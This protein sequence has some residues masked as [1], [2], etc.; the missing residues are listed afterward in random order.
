[1]KF[2]ISIDPPAKPAVPADVVSFLDPISI[3]A[4]FGLT[5]SEALQFFRQKGLKTSFDYK[6][7]IKEEHEA[8]FT[9]A[10]MLDMDMLGAVKDRID[11]AIASGTSMGEFRKELEPYLVKRGWWGQQSITDPLTGKKSIEKLGSAYRLNNI[12]RTNMQSAYSVGQWEQIQ[13]QAENAP[14]LMYD[15]VDDHRTRPE[16]VQWDGKT[17]PVNAPF[18]K[19]HY[20]PNDYGCRCG[21][22]QF[23]DSELKSMGLKPSKVPTVKWVN[24]T[25]P[26][27]GKVERV[28]EGVGPSFAYNPGVKRMEHLE[29][30]LNEKYQLLPEEMRA[31]AKAGEAKQLIE[32]LNK[33]TS[34]LPEGTTTSRITREEAKEAGSK[35]MDL[36]VGL[37]SEAARESGLGLKRSP[38]FKNVFNEVHSSNPAMVQIAEEFQENLMMQLHRWRA[39]NKAAKVEGKGKGALAVQKAS[40][41]FPDDWTEAADRLGKLYVKLSTNRGWQATLTRP[42][43]SISTFGHAYKKL[44]GSPYETVWPEGTGFIVTDESSTAA[45]EYAHRLQSAMPGLDRLFNEEHE[46]RT[47][48]DPLRYLSDLTGFNY[49]KAEVARE[50][51]Y[52]HPYQGREYKHLPEGYRAA[53]VISMVYEPLLGEMTPKNA[54]TLKKLIQHDPDMLSLALGLLFHYKP[55]S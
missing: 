43:R 29:G 34:S 25:N 55:D 4:G 17:L 27:T 8:A 6:D 1:M 23:D 13:R 22:L 48:G 50:D 28:P 16:H 20:P 49:G 46:A 26:R 5:A 45:H 41:R 3:T 35:I 19:T 36:L 54:V 33:A 10:K 42:S 31:A 30:L 53:E 38:L 40:K 7:L 51:N 11:E 18:W 47:Q 37:P 24:W 14:W 9:V 32:S 12:F 52:Y 15:A 21:V 39:T 44:G 2:R